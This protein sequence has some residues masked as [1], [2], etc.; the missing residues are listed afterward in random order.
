M[1]PSTSMPPFLLSPYLTISPPLSLPLY[2]THC[3]SHSPSP[4]HC[5][6]SLLSP[7][8]SHSVSI[9]FIPPPSSSPTKVMLKPVNRVRLTAAIA[10]AIAKRAAVNVDILQLKL[11][12]LNAPRQDSK[13]WT[14]RENLD[15]RCRDS[16]EDFSTPTSVRTVEPLI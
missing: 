10:E 7:T 16:R 11:E 1:P 14:S 15:I 12:T 5:L 4:P 2:L 8:L 3:P 13:I 6:F 9:T